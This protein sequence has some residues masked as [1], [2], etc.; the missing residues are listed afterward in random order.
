[1]PLLARRALDRARR[2]GSGGKGAARIALATG[3]GLRLGA[4]AAE[5]GPVAACVVG[6][7]LSRVG[8]FGCRCGWQQRGWRAG[9]RVGRA[10]FLA[11]GVCLPAAC[12][13]TVPRCP[14]CCS[15]R[16]TPPERRNHGPR[17]LAQHSRASSLLPSSAPCGASPGGTL[18]RCEYRDA[19]L[20]LVAPS[21]AGGCCANLRVKPRSYRA[22]RLGA[23]REARMMP[24][25]RDGFRD[26][27]VL[28]SI[29]V[30]AVVAYPGTFYHGSCVSGVE[31]QQTRAAAPAGPAAARETRAIPH[32]W[33]SES[34]SG[35]RDAG[36]PPG[37]ERRR[38][39]ELQPGNGLCRLVR[40]VGCPK[41]T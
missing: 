9:T 26:I 21:A 2:R 7:C 41:E 1:M 3:V 12:R 10:P 16:A 31:P 27:A 14:P 22:P 25:C 19:P 6:I 38:G 36:A 20:A 15:R 39:G 37:V 5:A 4:A 40:W 8:C 17:R 34:G 35:R 18:R 33:E 24:A 11:G 29:V 23:R 13:S 28:T 30:C 32:D